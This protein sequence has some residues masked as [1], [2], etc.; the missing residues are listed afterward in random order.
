MLDL[1]L[2]YVKERLGF[3]SIVEEGKAFAIFKTE[4]QE[5]YIQDIYV[6]PEYRKKGIMDAME[7]RIEAHAIE[8]G[9]TFAT[10]TVQPT[11]NNSE[12]SLVY[13]IGR[14]YKIVEAHP[15]VIIL[16]KELIKE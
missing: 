1:Y 11:A 13:C 8:K 3:E 2:S 6:A 14:G 7:G 16:R 10:G 4:G 15:N 5:I 9:C 12:E